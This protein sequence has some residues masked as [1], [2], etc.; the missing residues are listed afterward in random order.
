MIVT[1]FSQYNQLTYNYWYTFR[2]SSLFFAFVQ[3]SFISDCTKSFLQFFGQNFPEILWERKK[4]W[5]CA[6]RKIFVACQSIFFRYDVYI[7]ICKH[8]YTCFLSL[9][10][11]QSL[12]SLF[13]LISYLV[14]H[15]PMKWK[16]ELNLF[17]YSTKVFNNF[18]Y[19]LI[20]LVYLVM[21]N[22]KI[23]W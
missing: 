7:D 18:A 20:Y 21:W 19:F 9:Y 3:F 2:I 16:F 1:L 5:K 6:N 10:M 12:L 14:P 8:R 15:D 22:S 4:K 11:Q 23:V 17:E 13:N